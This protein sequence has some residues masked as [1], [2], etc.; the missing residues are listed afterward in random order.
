MKQHIEILLHVTV[1]QL[2]EAGELPA[3]PA[4]IQIDK[5]KNKRHGDFASNVALVL[6]KLTAK[7]PR[8]IAERIVALMPASPY[9]QKVEIADKGF[10]NFFLAPFG[11]KEIMANIMIEKE[12][13][14]R[15]KLGRGKRLLVEFVSSNPTGPLHVGHGRHAV[16]G[17]VLANLL[18]AVGFKT[19]HEYYINDAGRQTDILTLSIWLRYLNIC[20]ENI[21][22]PTNAYQGDYIVRIAQVI[23]DA[24]NKDFALT[25]TWQEISA[26]D[27]EIYLDLLIA[28]C[29]EML[30]NDKYQVFFNLGLENILADVREDLTEFGITFDN[31]VSE[32]KFMMTEPIDQLLKRL[33]ESGHVYE[34]ENALW[35]S[36]QAFG[37]KKDRVLKRKNGAYTYFANDI[38]YHI[39]KFERGYDIAI[40]ILGADHHGYVARLRAA[41]EASGIN[42]ERLQTLLIQFVTLYRQ[43]KKIPMSTQS[44]QAVTLRELRKEVG[45][46]A[47]RFFY[48][49][50]KREQHIDFNLDLAKAASNDNPVYYVQYAY[51]R[52]CSVFK[53]LSERQITFDLEN[54]LMHIEQLN[55]PT[56][57]R[58]LN[59][60]SYYPD[61]IISAALQYEPHQ[62]THYL[63]DLAADF[64]AY[65]HSHQF[66]IDDKVLRDA[67]LTL[68]T[69]A[70][71]IFTNGFALLGIT[72]PE[73]M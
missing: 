1:R 4:F 69:A 42:P 62:L 2:Q 34:K 18:D 31:W 57:Q 27:E 52:I 60:L 21:T 41:I 61:M 54:G 38:A 23:Y 71:Q 10:I 49:M 56:E 66:L 37:D 32:R 28:R 30:G 51:A 19:Y 70:K 50:R 33:R 67:R 44:G 17:A 3:I 22:F 11:F 7:T 16:F 72:A 46:D 64:H 48:L 35:F 6:A 68:L 15:C 29:K 43:A 58:L 14:G 24:H 12:R 45:N 8:E 26:N 73:N 36:A 5:T 59:T 40:D 9:V 53:Q 55:K 25:Q 65:Y 20:G 47:A 39:S 63:Y 13:F